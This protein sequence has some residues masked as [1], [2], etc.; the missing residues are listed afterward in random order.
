ML[1]VKKVLYSAQ[2]YNIMTVVTIYSGK[3]YAIKAQ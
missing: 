2:S 1:D 3:S